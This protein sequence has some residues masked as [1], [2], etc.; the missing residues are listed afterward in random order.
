M[1]SVASYLLWA[2]ALFF[3]AT[4]LFSSCF[5]LET[6]RGWGIVEWVEPLERRRGGGATDVPSSL[7]IRSDL[8]MV[9]NKDNGEEGGG[10]LP[11][12][13]AVIVLDSRDLVVLARVVF[14]EK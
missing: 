2:L 8:Y 1:A 13:W 4:A 11:C 5:R 6:R 3:W 14:L 10:N 9:V 12:K 7:S